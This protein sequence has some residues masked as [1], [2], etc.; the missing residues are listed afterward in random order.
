MQGVLTGGLDVLL[1]DQAE[2]RRIRAERP[3]L[4]RLTD[5]QLIERARGLLPT[6]RRLFERHL[7][8][9][10][11]ASIGPG[12]LAAVAEAMGDPTIALTLITGVGDVDSALPSREM[13]KLSRLDPDSDEFRRA[14][15][16]FLAE[17]GSR[18]PNEWDLISDVWETK[19]ELARSLI[20]VMRKQGPEGDPAG[21]SAAGAAEREA[22]T[23]QVRAAL[24][25]DPETLAQFEA[26]LSSAHTL[27]GGSRADEDEH[28]QGDPRDPDGVSG[29]GPSP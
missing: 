14:F 4:G 9:T 25:G 18:G 10:A 21:R 5:H 17:Y 11:G 29:V 7:T 24:A 23:S 8:V 16:A 3:D 15:D 12:I 22:V 13:W 28:H 2:A 20:D 6:V 1:E 26:G 19:P 27:P